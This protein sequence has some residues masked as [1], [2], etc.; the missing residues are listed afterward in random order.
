MKLYR[1]VDYFVFETVFKHACLNQ[2]ESSEYYNTKYNGLTIQNIQLKSH[3][4]QWYRDCKQHSR[5]ALL[6]AD[7]VLDSNRH[8]LAL[9][10]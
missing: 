8:I 2:N 4:V 9:V 5:A 10:S 1:Y 6:R 7:A 3:R